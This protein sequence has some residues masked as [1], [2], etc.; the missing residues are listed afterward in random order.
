MLIRDHGRQSERWAFTNAM[1]VYSK[2][3]E[4]ERIAAAIP[5]CPEINRQYR[6]ESYHSQIY[7]HLSFFKFALLSKT[8][9]LVYE[10]ATKMILSIGRLLFE[11]NMRLYPGRKWFWK[12]LLTLPDKPDGICQLMLRLLDKPNI[13]LEHNITKCITGY[14]NYPLPSEEMKQRIC[15]ESTM[16][17]AGW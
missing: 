8:K 11:D 14:E 4:I 16:N 13:E 6:M 10:M 2:D 3:P 12:E 5:I 7:Y 9:Y 1:V 15:K 17:L